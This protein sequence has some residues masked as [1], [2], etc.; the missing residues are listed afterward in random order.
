MQG[1]PALPARQ[2]LSIK[3]V[4][5]LL[6]SLLV[7]LA[8]VGT[9]LY[10][11]WQLEGGAAAINAAG[12]LRMQTYRLGYTLQLNREHPS[13]E[14]AAQIEHERGQFAAT[15]ALL[16]RGDP[17]RPL[18]LPSD[19]AVRARFKAIEQR[20]ERLLAMPPSTLKRDPADM[21]VQ[22]DHFVDQINGLVLDI[23][24]YNARRTMLMRGSQILLIALAI[25]G[26][27]AQIYLMF[28]LVFRPLYRLSGG[29][30]RMAERDYS[31]RLPV[32]TD[33]E[34]GELTRSFNRMA[35]R[36]ADAHGSLE[37][38]VA[39]KTDALNTRN[40][41]LALRNDIGARLNAGL[42]AESMC[43]D[44]LDQLIAWFGADGGSVRIVDP[45][46]NAAHMVVYEGISDSLAAA[47]HCLQPGDCLCGTSL[48]E[49]VA[50]IQDFRK[51]PMAAAPY[52]CEREGFVQVSAF[53]IRARTRST[54]QFNMHFRIARDITRSERD[55]LEALGEQ[56]GIALENLRL[57]ARE[58]EIAV[59]EERNLLAQGLHDS[60]AQGL[61]FLNLQVQMLND[62]LKRG[63][64]A[65][66][67]DIV[68]LLKAGVQESYDDVRE[69]LNNFRA[70]L[71][72]GDLV[73]S[74]RATIERFRRQTGIGVDFDTS[75]SG[76]P[77]PAED[78][79]QLLFVL[80]EALSN[81]RKH[82]YATGVRV[83][84]V[85]ERDVTLT[86]HDD[87][88]GFD[89]AE[90]AARA[91]GHV[92]LKIMQERASRLAAQLRIDSD[93][94]GVVTLT[95]PAEARRL[96]E[97]TQERTGRHDDQGIAG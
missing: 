50:I 31:V 8:A 51:L 60:I 33:D 62:S 58:R 1:E 49:G 89:A 36:V 79:L 56:L 72:E 23:E 75:G 24:Q 6:V 15:L 92:G 54:G 82:A 88:R 11:S 44:F 94:G 17:A 43:R 7:G 32:E 37:A 81:V 84:F 48:K 85:N 45:H 78:Q 93:H 74:M 47:E 30:S 46:S 70:R 38:R 71:A 27:V 67:L 34:F 76:A 53:P 42:S 57:A 83:R 66:A 39:Q 12:S 55:L 97:R 16:D 4:A 14:L 87:G 29:I 2:Q 25:V 41:E 19:P 95:I 65:E 35:D 96:D 77:L 64:V 13:P 18:Y 3:V 28:L 10:L 73:S 21:R 22:M 52:S 20:Y 86:I 90:M 69:L 9:T 68:P 63:D 80:Q 40:R 59:Y 61:S 26:T 91:E 5:L